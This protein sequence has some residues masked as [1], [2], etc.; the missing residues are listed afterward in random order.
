[1]VVARNMNNFASLN[2][3]GRIVQNKIYVVQIDTSICPNNSFFDETI[4][5][6]FPFD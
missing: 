4:W 5:P 1:M 6:Y 3:T 2:I